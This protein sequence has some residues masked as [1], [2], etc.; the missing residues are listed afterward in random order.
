M[1]RLA[2][3]HPSIVGRGQAHGLVGGLHK[4]LVLPDERDKGFG[5]DLHHPGR[6]PELAQR[7]HRGA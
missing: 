1:A 6:V 3:R 2:G 5:Y 7:E 4:P